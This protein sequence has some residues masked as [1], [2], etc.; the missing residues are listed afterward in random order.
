[1]ATYISFYTA[2][3]IICDESGVDMEALQQVWRTSQQLR[4][5]RIAAVRCMQ[6]GACAWNVW[7][8]MTTQL[9]FVL[10]LIDRCAV[11]FATAT[12]LQGMPDLHAG[13]PYPIGTAF[14]TEGVV[15]P[16]LIGGNV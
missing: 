4:G 5:I 8:E 15:H 12:A 10:C 3:R 11:L 2:V 6:P 7:S 14:V 13:S 16:C 9:L 1:M